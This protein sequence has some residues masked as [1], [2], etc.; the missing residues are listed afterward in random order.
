MSTP[1]FQID[2]KQ[3]RKKKKNNYHFLKKKNEKY[4]GSF[5]SGF[6]GPRCP[7][8]LSKTHFHMYVNMQFRFTRDRRN[9]FTLQTNGSILHPPFAHQPLKAFRECC[10]C[11]TATVWGGEGKIFVR[12]L[13]AA[14]SSLGLEAI[15]TLMMTHTS[16]TDERYPAFGWNAAAV[17]AGFPASP[18]PPH[19]FGRGNWK[20][21]THT[22][23]K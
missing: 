16:I 11:S 19:F 10:C 1:S 12:V 7:T 13:R 9:I 6:I 8:Q 15:V 22:R 17:V 3:K 5:Q 20:N 2:S 4:D 18:P 14:E 23:K 21:W